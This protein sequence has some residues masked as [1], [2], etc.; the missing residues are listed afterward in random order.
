[1]STVDTAGTC[2]CA[3]TATCTARLLCCMYVHTICF[4][5]AVAHCSEAG[6]ERRHA[7]L[8]SQQRPSDPTGRQRSWQKQKGARQDPRAGIG[9]QGPPRG[10]LLAP[11]PVLV[12]TVGSQKRCYPPT[13]MR[14][15]SPSPG[16]CNGAP[17]LRAPLSLALGCHHSSD[18]DHTAG[19]LL[20]LLG[21]HGGSTSVAAIP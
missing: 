19:A 6:G 10:P 15:K 1:M 12:R 4:L 3:C 20:A 16:A 9:T 18:C 17:T 5:L 13:L 7:T 11:A 14:Y 8:F 2:A 21:R